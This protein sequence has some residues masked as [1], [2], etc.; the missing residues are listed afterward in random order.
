MIAVL[1]RTHPPTAIDTVEALCDAIARDDYT[2]EKTLI[3]MSSIDQD[4]R[5]AVKTL[6]ELPREIGTSYNAQ[7]IRQW[8]DSNAS[9]AIVAI[10]L[11]E[12]VE[13]LR[14]TCRFVVNQ[15]TIIGIQIDSLN[16]HMDS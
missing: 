4:V 6:C 3:M 14:F 1:A 16:I 2:T 15:W 10:P 12:K 9:F 11:P 5:Q 13:S 8:D 7:V